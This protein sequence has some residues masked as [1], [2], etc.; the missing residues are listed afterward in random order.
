MSFWQ[1]KPW[2][3]IQ[4]IM[5]NVEFVALEWK[6]ANWKS[7]N[8]SWFFACCKAKR[9]FSRYHKLL[10]QG[11]LM[12]SPRWQRTMLHFNGSSDKRGISLSKQI[13]KELQN[14]QALAREAFTLIFH[15]TDWASKFCTLLQFPVR[16]WEI[17]LKSKTSERKVFNSWR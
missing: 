2:G 8:L 10:Q 13:S 15:L 6:L 11:K 16:D 4:S 1:M 17:K 3:W 9:S 12:R 14:F 7:L 5:V